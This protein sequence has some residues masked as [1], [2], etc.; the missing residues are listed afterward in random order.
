MVNLPGQSKQFPNIAKSNGTS[1][2]KKTLQFLMTE[3]YK[4]KTNPAPPI[5]HNLFQF[6][7]NTLIKK[8]NLNLRHFRDL[9]HNQKT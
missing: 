6:H 5:L 8:Y 9:T 1:R 4:I 2:H 3:I 7:E